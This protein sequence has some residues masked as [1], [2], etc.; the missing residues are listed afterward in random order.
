MEES[1]IPFSLSDYDVITVHLST[2]KTRSNKFWCLNQVVLDE[3]LCN[4]IKTMV[5]KQIGN[6]LRKSSPMQW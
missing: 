6:L 4:G 1:I 2:K 5:L 3:E